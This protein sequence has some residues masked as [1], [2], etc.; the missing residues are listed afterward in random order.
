[1]KLELNLQ[2]FN[3]PQFL[4]ESERNGKGIM[5]PIVQVIENPEDC[6]DDDI[7]VY[8][9][10]YLIDQLVHEQK[11]LYVNFSESG[12]E[13]EI[14]CIDGE[15][16]FLIDEKNYK[17]ELEDEDGYLPEDVIPVK[18]LYLSESESLGYL[19][20]YENGVLTIQSAIYYLHGKNF[21]GPFGS[22][23]EIEIKENVEIFEQ[24]MLEYIKRYVKK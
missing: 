11:Y 17:F 15:T 23:T 13:R 24:P 19:L 9:S 1:M 20:K 8:E 21:S 12:L 14:K 7:E 4:E 22:T 6:W 3:L 10:E 5:S 18:D 2:K 16:Y